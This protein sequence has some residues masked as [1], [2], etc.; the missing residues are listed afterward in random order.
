MTTT[1]VSKVETRRLVAGNGRHIRMATVVV[2]E[3]GVEVQFTERMSKRAAVE[4][5]VAAR[6]LHPESFAS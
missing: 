4:Q 2:F 3:D 5:A 6:Q 1:N